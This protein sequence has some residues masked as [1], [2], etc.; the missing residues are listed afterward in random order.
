MDTVGGK[1]VAN[2]DVAERVSSR[3]A[4]SSLLVLLGVMLALLA[5]QRGC[6]SASGRRTGLESAQRGRLR[7]ELKLPDTV[8]SGKHV[9]IWLIVTNTSSDSV[10]L[11]P[12]TRV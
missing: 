5:I 2:R 9:P 11:V 12:D 10:R 1:W 4:T 3:S 8:R 6:R 7:L